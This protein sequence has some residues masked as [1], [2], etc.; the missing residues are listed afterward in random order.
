MSQIPFTFSACV[1][2]QAHTI[3]CDGNPLCCQEMPCAVVEHAGEKVYDRRCGTTPDL[4]P[5]PLLGTTPTSY[6]Q[7]QYL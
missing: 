5:A 4:A 2:A 7:E 3:V 6:R 1:E